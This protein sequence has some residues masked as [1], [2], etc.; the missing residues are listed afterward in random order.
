MKITKP[1]DDP[2]FRRHEEDQLKKYFLL[3]LYM[4]FVVDN[5]RIEFSLFSS[6]RLFNVT[7]YPEH[8]RTAPCG[9][10]DTALSRETGSHLDI[11]SWSSH[12]EMVQLLLWGPR[13]PAWRANDPRRRESDAP[14]NEPSWESKRPQKHAWD[15]VSCWLT[16]TVICRSGEIDWHRDSSHNQV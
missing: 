12:G 6:V 4:M 2:H 1:S 14:L 13:G 7:F 9:W 11:S 8:R 10:T 16:I 3:L 15:P 5:H